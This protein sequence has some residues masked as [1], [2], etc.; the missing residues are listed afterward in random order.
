[1]KFHICILMVVL[2]FLAGGGLL[3]ADE[4]KRVAVVP[5][6]GGKT[7]YNVACW[8]KIVPRNLEWRLSQLAS[9]QIIPSA[10]VAFAMR[11]LE[12]SPEG[13]REVSARSLADLLGA[14]YVVW[15]ALVANSN[16]VQVNFSVLDSESSAPAVL[17]APRGEWPIE[18]ITAVSGRIAG[19]LDIKLTEAEERR[20]ACGFTSDRRAG[21][22][23]AKALRDMNDNLPF[24]EY[25]GDLERAI[26]LDPSFAIARVVMAQCLAQQGDLPQA[27]QLAKEATAAQPQYAQGHSVLG[28]IY[29]LEG[30][31]LVAAV[32]ELRRALELDPALEAACR[33]LTET[34]AAKGRLED[35]TE[36]LESGLKRDEYNS[37]LWA[38]KARLLARSGE[39]QEAMAA[40]GKAERFADPTDP[41]AQMSLGKLYRAMHDIPRAVSC[42]ESFLGAAEQRGVAAGNLRDIR[43]MVSE[44]R[45]SLTPQFVIAK[46]PRDYSPAEL[47]AEAEARLDRSERVLTQYPLTWSEEMRAW[48]AEAVKGANSDLAKASRL[49]QVVTSRLDVK[50]SGGLR[51]AEEAF[52][53]LGSSKVLKCEE[54][55]LLYV[56]LARSVGLR[57]F[58][59]WVTKDYRG[60]LVNHACA[61]L[62]VGAKALLVDPRYLWFGAPHE[63]FQIQGDLE[64]M[65][66]YL[67]QVD[68]TRHRRAATH[69]C[70]QCPLPWLNLAITLAAAGNDLEARS[71][72]EA[73]MKLK[74]PAWVGSYVLGT[75]EYY[76]TDQ[77]AATSDL[78]RSLALNPNNEEG[79]YLFASALERTHKYEQAAKEYRLLLC[80]SQNTDLRNAAKSGLARLAQKALTT[81][82]RPT[83]H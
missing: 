54:Y 10:S 49:Y 46:P 65:A 11:E 56:A 82:E 51:T 44:L 25:R 79:Q 41:D 23:L 20:M 32:A 73:G 61:A 45:Q 19:I 18:N 39:R 21:E 24:T 47:K 55:A 43:A 48:A 72:L 16:S 53:E 68:D 62:F 67:A 17:I 60:A 40:L 28:Y 12:I 64:T 31:N 69:L 81:D 15:G 34:L 52:S 13:I 33:C 29:S 70:P 83:T 22:L 7:D 9:L 63:E 26:A 80:T 58:F 37:N 35:A 1:M 36:V 4:T 14:R 50:G 3:F 76:G 71:S 66:L 42:F 57:A 74:P 2:W 5:T 6:F 27:M 38:L 75:V 8:G 30:S 77:E 59:V 78:G